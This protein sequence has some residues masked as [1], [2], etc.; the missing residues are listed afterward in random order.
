MK[1]KGRI[2]KIPRYD[3]M[4]AILDSEGIKEIEFGRSYQPAPDE[5]K[6]VFE[7]YLED[8]AFQFTTDKEIKEA[9]R[10][11]SQT[12]RKS[13]MSKKRKTKRKVRR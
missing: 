4:Y 1:R 8:G 7:E 12:K 2:K 6:A 9:Y 11:V 13:K 3:K 5:I 10:R